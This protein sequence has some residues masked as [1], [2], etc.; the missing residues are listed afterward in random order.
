MKQKFF[1]DHNEAAR[2]CW[3]DVGSNNFRIYDAL[4]YERAAQIQVHPRGLLDKCTHLTIAASGDTR[5]GH[6][7]LIIAPYRLD[8][9]KTTN[10]KYYDIDPV[11]FVL[12]SN[13]GASHPSGVVAYHQSFPNRNCPVP[14]FA[15]T[16]LDVAVAELRTKVITGLQP[17]SM[18][19]PEVHE[20]MQ[21]MVTKF[22]SDFLDYGEDCIWE[23][24]VNSL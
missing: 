3:Q 23:R 14:G 18:A 17:L 6:D 5:T 10:E 19:Q 11:L 15:E 8:S 12:D 13:T 24:R 16:P 20:A 21:H 22:K 9:S 7:W 4:G 1:A 2:K